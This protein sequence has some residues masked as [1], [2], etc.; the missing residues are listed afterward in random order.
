MFSTNLNRDG[1][2]S[3]VDTLV[4]NYENPSL[5]LFMVLAYIE[6]NRTRLLSMKNEQDLDTFLE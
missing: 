4:S 2:L 6:Y 5:I 1:F 3:V